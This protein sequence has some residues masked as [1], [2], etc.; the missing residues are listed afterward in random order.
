M[1]LRNNTAQGGVSSL[2]RLNGNITLEPGPG[3]TIIDN[4]TTNSIRLSTITQAANLDTVLQNG[5]RTAR[6]IN[7]LTNVA[8]T[9]PTLSLHDNISI[10]NS[11]TAPDVSISYTDET[12]SGLK[13]TSGKIF[14]SDI[15]GAAAASS[16]Q[17]KSGITIDPG[18]TLKTDYIDASTTGGKLQV[19]DVQLAMDKTLYTDNIRSNPN[20]PTRF[21]NT[22][23][24]AV[25]PMYSVKASAYLPSGSFTNAAMFRADDGTIMSTGTL[26]IDAAVQVLPNKLLKC[27]VFTSSTDS[28][29][30]LTFNMPAGII[31]APN[32]LLN[33]IT[34][35]KVQAGKSMLC[36]R[37]IDTNSSKMYVDLANAAIQAAQVIL[38]SDTQI[39]NFKTSNISGANADSGITIN[40]PV[41]GIGLTPDTVLR[42]DTIHAVSSNNE[43]E[44]TS[45]ISVD[46][47]LNLKVKNVVS[48]S[49]ILL[50]P[51]GDVVVDPAKILKTVNIRSVSNVV[52]ITM[53]SDVNIGSIGT[54]TKT[55]NTDHIRPLTDGGR[56]DFSDTTMNDL[57]VATISPSVGGMII[58]MNKAS[59][60]SGTTVDVV[61]NLKASSL[62]TDAISTTSTITGMSIDLV[63]SNI[64]A[65]GGVT[66]SNIKSQDATFNSITPVTKAIAVNGDIKMLQDATVYT[67]KLAASV[68]QNVTVD[69]NMIINP[70]NKL[71][72]DNI[73]VKAINNVNNPFGLRVLTDESTITSGS[74]IL[75]TPNNLFKVYTPIQCDTY[76]PLTTNGDI[77]LATVTGANV[78][79]G[80]LKANKIIAPTGSDLTLTTTDFDRGIKAIGPLHVSQITSIGTSLGVLSDT[81][82]VIASNN[83]SMSATNATNIT[84]N[85]ATLQADSVT[86]GKTGNTT[87]NLNSATINIGGATGKTIINNTGIQFKSTGN[88]ILSAYEENVYTGTLS[89]IATTGT[90]SF[91]FRFV[92]V[93]KQVSVTL[94][95]QSI[96]LQLTALGGSTFSQTIDSKYCA[97]RTIIMPMIGIKGDNNMDLL[98][99]LLTSSGSLIIAGNPGALYIP[100]YLE[101]T[102]SYCVNTASGVTAAVDPIGFI[103]ETLPAEN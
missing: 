73:D 81:I 10:G 96:V 60:T 11:K 61:A 62:D 69:N 15:I 72:A 2:D 68:A 13:M 51:V 75:V 21:I 26:S 56:T 23:G 91:T 67:D 32:I 43:I 74:N 8:D 29:D 31:G 9:F 57:K 12:P 19:N 85:T 14:R 18:M 41:G 53:S 20:S 22:G 80:N 79:V 44:V 86:I 25:D 1:S 64:S 27:D 63:N 35:V 16:I 46:P 83:L 87:I 54:D 77:T 17:S 70:A 38:Q 65:T 78:V 45:N 84:S 94:D 95:D 101:M 42:T 49:D 48:E 66:V 7:L 99:C 3:M 59:I 89:N 28:N 52:P 58:D 102:A 50:N 90:P 4:A 93:G 34:S 88:A 92:K 36:D 24:I 5:D 30:K 103:P 100:Y 40:A 55:L 98:R 47:T 82:G 76:Q 6:T 97:T 71:I 33:P 37:V 39:Q